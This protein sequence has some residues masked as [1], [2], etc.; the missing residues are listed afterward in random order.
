MNFWIFVAPHVGAW[1]ETLAPAASIGRVYVA[2][3]AGAWIETAERRGGESQVVVA[4]HVGAWIETVLL[5]D[6]H[7]AFESRPTRA[8]GLKQL[9]GIGRVDV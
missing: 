7:R 2:P 9:Q 1:I 8:R 4:P 5:G 3:H 6:E